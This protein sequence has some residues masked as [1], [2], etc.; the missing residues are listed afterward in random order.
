M[1]DAER[2]AY[3]AGGDIDIANKLDGIVEQVVGLV[4]GKV[5]SCD[6][7][8]TLGAAGE[9]PDELLWA[10]ATIGKYSLVAVIPGMDEEADKIRM[11][12][13]RSAMKQ[14]DDAAACKIGIAP[15]AGL[16]PTARP[17]DYGG[18]AILDF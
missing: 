13:Y 2:D 3:E 16:E 9:I 5:S 4:R 14:L 7:I 18:A 11:E 17:S 6:N 12:E 10:A 8:S 1:A 15:P